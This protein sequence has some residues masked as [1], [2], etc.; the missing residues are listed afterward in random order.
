MAPLYLIA[1]LSAADIV[2]HRDTRQPSF[3][4]LSIKERRA[5]L[6]DESD[7]QLTKLYAVDVAADGGVW[8][9]VID[10][11]NRVLVKRFVKP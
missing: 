11:Q 1:A 7:G 4:I 8:K 10:R 3:K 5:E 2:P 9:L 6:S